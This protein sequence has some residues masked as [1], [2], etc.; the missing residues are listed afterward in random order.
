[1]IAGKECLCG[2]NAGFR[3]QETSA[4]RLQFDVTPRPEL[5]A[6]T[7]HHANPGVEMGADVDADGKPGRLGGGRDRILKMMLDRMR[8]Q[9][10][11]FRNSAITGEA[12]S[13][14]AERAYHGVIGMLVR[15][16]H[17]AEENV[18]LRLADLAGQSERVLIR[19]F[20]MGVPA[21]INELNLRAEDAGGG[22][23]FRF[24]FLCRP[25]AAGLAARANEKIDFAAAGRFA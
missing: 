6:M 10:T 17:G 11:H 5:S 21:Q 3:A 23:G 13:V 7:F 12:G 24:P 1:M 18:R 2:R 14:A 22:A 4:R 15:G 25:I 8:C 9:I 20:K 16:R 19:D